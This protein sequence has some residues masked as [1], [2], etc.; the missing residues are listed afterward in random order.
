MHSL[1]I[2]TE[3]RLGH[4]SEIADA[5]HPQNSNPTGT[6]AEKMSNSSYDLIILGSGAGGGTLA[7]KLAPSG[8]RILI[9][10]R[11]DSCRERNR[12]GM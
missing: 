5:G 12:T 6:E 11:G 4:I 7:L 3:A 2:F 9:R 1:V 10:E 8:Q